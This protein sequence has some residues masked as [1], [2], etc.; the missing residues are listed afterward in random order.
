VAGYF[1][2]QQLDQF[3]REFDERRF[4][5]VE[6]SLSSEQVPQASATRI[7]TACRLPR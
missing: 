5:A 2:G 3:V 4:L 7:V 6:D 1:S